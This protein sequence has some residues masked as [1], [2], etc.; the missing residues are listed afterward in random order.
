[1]RRAATSS[2]CRCA[3]GSRWTTSSC[4]AAN[5]PASSPR[6]CRRRRTGRRPRVVRPPHR[7]PRPAR[8]PPS[9]GVVVAHLGI[10]AAAAAPRRPR[11]ASRHRR[12][13]LPARRGRPKLR[14]TTRYRPACADSSTPNGP[15]PWPTASGC[16]SFATNC[17]IC[18]LCT[19]CCSTSAKSPRNRRRAPGPSWDGPTGCSPSPARP[20]SAA[21]SSATSASAW[22]PTSTAPRPSDWPEKASGD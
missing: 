19:S 11:P 6:S 12:R 5:T 22:K 7:P 10:R 2:T 1:M 15:T 3:E 20:T 21:S 8:L 17:H 13:P 16:A 18:T 9:P 14:G 4:W